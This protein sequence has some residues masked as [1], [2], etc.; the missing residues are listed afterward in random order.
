MHNLAFSD[1]SDGSYCNGSVS[2]RT[3]TYAANVMFV[4][5]PVTT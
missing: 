2:S 3:I 5:Q 1:V 4:C